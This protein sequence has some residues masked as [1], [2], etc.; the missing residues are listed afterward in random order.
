LIFFIF[1]Q[2]FSFV[3]FFVFDFKAAVVEGCAV[4][5]D[6]LGANLSTKVAAACGHVV[7]Y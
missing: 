7:L 5:A 1:L 6:L 4:I 3:G 2:I